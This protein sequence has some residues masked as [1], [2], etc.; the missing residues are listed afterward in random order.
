MQQ[1]STA[2]LELKHEAREGEKGRYRYRRPTCQIKEHL[3]ER[4]LESQH[5]SQDQK[6]CWL[7]RCQGWVHEQVQW[8]VLE[9]VL[10]V[11]VVTVGEWQQYL[12]WQQPTG[13][14]PLLDVASEYGQRW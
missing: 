13:H 14:Q 2:L 10:V 9:E 4:R 8:V 11:A 5:G 12:Q 6:E 7:E 3:L 1:H